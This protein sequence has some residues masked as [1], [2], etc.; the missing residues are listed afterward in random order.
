M[1]DHIKDSELNELNAIYEQKLKAQ[2]KGRSKSAKSV[3]STE[4]ASDIKKAASSN[5]DK[6]NA[7]E[8][9]NKTLAQKINIGVCAS[10]FAIVIVCLLVL[11]R[12]T[13]SETEKRE[14]AKFPEFSWDAY[15][16]GKYTADI[17]NFFNDT[18]P[19]RDELKQMGAVF[20]SMFGFTLDGADF[21][22]EINNINSGSQTEVTTQSTKPIEIVIPKPSESDNSSAPGESGNS[23]SDTPQSSDTNSGGTSSDTPKPSEALPP[24]NP[25]TQTLYQDGSMIVYSAGDTIYAGTLYYGDRQYAKDYANAVNSVK[26]NLPGVNVYSMT[27]LTQNTFITPRELSDRKYDYTEQSDAAYLRNML[28]SDIKVIDTFDLLAPHA[29]EDIFFLRDPR[30][31]QL[32]AYYAAQGFAKAAGVDFAKLSDYRMDDSRAALSII[33][34][35]TDYE[36]LMYEG[37]TFTYYVP[38][39]EYKMDLYD[40][41]YSLVIEDYPLMSEADFAPSSFYSLFMGADSNIKH[42]TTDT[43]NGRVLVVLKD[44]YPSAM[45]PCLTSSFE[46]IYVIDVRYCNFNPIIFAKEHGATDVLIGMTVESALGGEAGTAFEELISL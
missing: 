1:A 45:I 2:K 13:V 26:K 41:D 12:P 34:A 46:E 29:N 8:D 30:W 6:N 23:S 14:L 10:F 20:R 11:P 33:Y 15:W 16:S 44:D 3:K 36:G 5:H 21:S 24:S 18:V 43:D 7:A 37:E 17:S 28:D 22:G 40:S 27:A 25:D 35:L 19:F 31:Q 39:N 42:I 9:K 32:G 4:K 38:Q